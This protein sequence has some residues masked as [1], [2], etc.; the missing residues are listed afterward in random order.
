MGPGGM[1]GMKLAEF[2]FGNGKWE[3]KD[4]KDSLN[5]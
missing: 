1:N 5:R 2:W 4:K 3:V